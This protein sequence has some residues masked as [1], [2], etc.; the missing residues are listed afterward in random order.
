MKIA[1]GSVFYSLAS[2]RSICGIVRCSFT[3]PLLKLI[4]FLSLCCFF[5]RGIS[6]SL[7]LNQINKGGGIEHGQDRKT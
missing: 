2:E 5:L 4:L 1:K 3:Y 7:L 6:L